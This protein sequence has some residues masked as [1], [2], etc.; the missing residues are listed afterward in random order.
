MALASCA[1][2]APPP[3]IAPNDGERQRPNILW[4]ISEDNNPF[5][6]VYGDALVASE[7]Y[8]GH[9]A[10]YIVATLNGTFAPERPWADLRR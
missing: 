5:V 3:F 6:G 4:L 2:A 7:G 9:L 1:G 10:S 8:I